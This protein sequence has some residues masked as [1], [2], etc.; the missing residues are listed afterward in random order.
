MTTTFS[1]RTVL[2]ATTGR[3][4][5]LRQDPHNNGIGDLY[6]LLGWMTGDSPCTHHLPRYADVCK[7]W[8]LQWF[9]ILQAAETVLPQLDKLI[10]AVGPEEGVALWIGQLRDLG[11]PDAFDVPRI[12]EA[13]V[14]EMP[15]LLAGLEGSD[16][17]IVVRG[18]G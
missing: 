3:F 17:L 2:T 7:P 8:L 11:F 1:L 12:A 5:C 15:E 18:E 13:A 16:V 9:P 10:D 14:P 4:L 6:K